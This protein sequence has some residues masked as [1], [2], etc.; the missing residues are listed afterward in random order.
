MIR[1]ALTF[2]VGTAMLTAADPL[3]LQLLP[4]LAADAQLRVS[5]TNVTKTDVTISFIG[6][7]VERQNAAGKFEAFRSDVA[8]PCRAQCKHPMIDL[9]A[10]QVVEAAWDRRSS[11]C[12]AATDGVFRFVVIDRY[13]E[14]LQGYVYHG[15]S[16]AFALT[17][18]KR[19]LAASGRRRSQSVSIERIS[20]VRPRP[21][22]SL[23]PTATAVTPAADAAVA[24][25]AA[26]AEH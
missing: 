21:N 23:Q 19:D 6:V 1:K 17:D 13:S 26:V 24:P 18:G 11:D 20:A 15:V 14:A 10:G 8:C 22:Q 2:F 3:R 7:D 4:S 9:Q 5:V 16:D 12:T 25:A